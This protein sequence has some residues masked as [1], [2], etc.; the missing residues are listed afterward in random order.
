MLAKIT[1][2]NQITIP[3]KIMA[4]LLNVEHFDIEFK[5]GVVLLKPIKV[6]DTSLDRIRTK[7][8]ELGLKPDSV[9]EAIKWAGK[10]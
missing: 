2:K 8:A 4:Q 6:L 3:K 5:D 9:N 1:A 7:I 10:K